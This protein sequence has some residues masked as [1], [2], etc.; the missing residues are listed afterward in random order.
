MEETQSFRLAGTTEIQKIPTHCI[1]GQSVVYWD[2]IE[3]VFPGARQVKNGNVAIPRCIKSFPSAVLDVVLSSAIEYL[4]VDSSVKI[5]SVIPT[6][7]P[8]PALTV[9]L[10]DTLADLPTDFPTSE[11]QLIETL[12][13][14]SVLAETPINDVSAHASSTGSSMLPSTSISKVKAT[15]K[16]TLSFKQVVQLASKREKA[17]DSQVQMPEPSANIAHMIKLQNA[18]DAKQEKFDA[19]QEKTNQLLNQVLEQ[20]EEMNRLQK[21]A[22]EGQEEVNR[23]QKQVLEEQEKMNRLQKQALEEQEK[24]NQ[25]QIQNQEESRHMHDEAIYHQKEMIQLQIHNQEELRQMHVKVMG[26][27]AVLQSQAQAILTQTFE[28]HEYPIPRLFIVL[29]QEP[30]R[31]DAVNPFSNKFRLYFLCECGEHTKSANSKT[32]IP[33][34]I[35]LAKHEGYDIARPSEFFRQYGE[36]VLTILKMLKLGITVAGVVMPALSQL[37]SPD[38]IGQSIDSLK[39]LQDNIM[40]TVDQVIEWMDKVAVDEGEAVEDVSVSGGKDSEDVAK[41]LE[42]KEALEGA[43]LRKLN[44]FLQG[45]DG[46]KVLGNLYRTVTV[47]GHVKWVCIDHY[48]ENYQENQANAFR[49]SLGTVGGSFDENTGLVTAKLR[50]RLLAEQFYAALKN[51]RSVLEL[52]VD[53]VFE[54]TRNDLEELE[55]ALRTSSISIL[56]LD[57]Q[58]FQTSIRSSISTQHKILFRIM[59][60]PNMKVIRIVLRKE[61]G[62][63]SSL[64][65]RNASH[66]HSL[67]FEMVVKSDGGEDIVIIAEALK[68]NSTP[69]TWCLYANESEG[70]WAQVPSEA[71]ST[72]STLTTL[73]LQNNSIGDNGAQAVSEALKINSTLITLNLQKNSI[74]HLGA[75]AL[76]E[77]LKINS[78]LTSLTLGNNSIGGDGVQALSEAFKINSTLTT[79]NLGGNFLRGNGAQ[80]LSEALKINSTLTTL[81]LNWSFIGGD[82]AQALSEA[83]MINSTLTTLNLRDNSIGHHGAQ[84]LSEALKINLTLTTLN[85]GYNLIGGNGAQ[86]LSEALKINSTLTTLNLERNSIGGDGAQAL[87]EALKINSTLTNLDLQINSIGDNGAQAL[88]EALTI[89]STL[90]N[91]DLQIN[92]IGDNGAQ[93]LSEALTIN[94]TLTTL[95]L[96]DNS[97]EDDGAQMLSDM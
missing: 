84:A 1:D 72:N 97:I 49:R 66:L 90:T 95:N 86:A 77:A 52:D 65:P 80:A 5:P 68:T 42:T 61:F 62:K 43:D 58:H 25:L 96:Q 20:Q 17:Y 85:L 2:S 73:N 46:N 9:G 69:I 59:E 7:N 36:Y 38:V 35:H 19:Q 79:L 70:H 78:T 8:A 53:L 54:C 26:Q 27:L 16:T 63:L 37:I 40:P 81:D 33:H 75:Q 60:L 51:S 87:S 41:Q 48:R 18:F 31:W 39:Q 14:T 15:S 45:K 28:L 93:A 92:S 82:G 24:M 30:S 64:Q 74:G 88:S 56:R 4:D 3:Q 67:S 71:A 50:S 57:H 47:E 83:L 21:Q 32:K 44:S 55:T 89:N 94:S 13:V 6:V 22:R 29:P 10:A 11:D 23:L 12:R 91:L 76:S 34:H